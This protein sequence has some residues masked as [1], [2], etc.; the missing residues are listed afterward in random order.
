VS[1]V[2]LVARLLLA[3]VFAFAA[4][5]KLG[6]TAET[7]STGE[8]FGFP[9]HLRR[10]VAVALPAI[11]LLIAGALLPAAS[12]PYAAVAATLL[13]AAFSFAIAR[14]LIRGEEV[15]CNCF[16]S[17]GD[18]RITRSTLVRDLVLL[19]PAT[20]IAAA[21]WGDAGPSAVAWVGEVDVTAAV[22]IVAG[23]ALVAAVAGL[24]LAWQLMRQNGR[25]LERLDALDAGGDG[26]AVPRRS[27][28]AGRPMPS[29]SLPDLSGREVSLEGLLDDGRELLLLFTDPGC[30]ACNPLLPEMGRRQREAGDGPLPVVMSLGDVETNRVKASEHGLGLVLLQDDFDLARSL[31]ITGMPGAVLVDREGRI[32]G[33][34]VDNSDRVG[35]LLAATETERPAATLEVTT[36]GGRR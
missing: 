23:L 18:D 11:E 7:E 3:A 24:A 31:G 4:V 32:S 16:G 30:H 36:V 34:P 19:V 25:L 22:A 12:A 20:L 13:L 2:L 9:V 10:P 21:G 27:K 6:R 29:F 35:E 14:V 8:A 33:E 5:A 15:E 26:A 1:T 28:H 17:L